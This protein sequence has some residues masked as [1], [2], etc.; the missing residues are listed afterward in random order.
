[1]R[2]QF[3]NLSIGTQNILFNK[4]KHKL[5]THAY[6][7]MHLQFGHFAYTFK[8]RIRACLFVN[9]HIASFTIKDVIIIIQ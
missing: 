5:N 2:S 3:F 7:L 4:K 1:M 9:N 6:I 8:Q